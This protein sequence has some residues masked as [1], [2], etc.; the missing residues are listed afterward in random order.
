M[1]VMYARYRD[2]GEQKPHIWGY[3]RYKSDYTT[4]HTAH[5]PN[6]PRN[7]KNLATAQA[8]TTR[9]QILWKNLV[10]A[11][12]SALGVYSSLGQ[13]KDKTA[14]LSLRA[15]LNPD[16]PAVGFHGHA[17]ESQ[18]QPQTSPALCLPAY[19]GKLFKYALTLIR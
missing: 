18:S 13:S 1:R 8:N 11:K 3:L 10:S 17:A 5:K 15:I 16:T 7:L 19:L 9:N 4:H 6:S 14:T 12:S 2:R